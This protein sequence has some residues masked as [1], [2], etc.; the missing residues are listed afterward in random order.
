MKKVIV[1]LLSVSFLLVGCSFVNEDKVKIN[2]KNEIDKYYENLLLEDL[3]GVMK[4][5]SSDSEQYYDLYNEYR[6]TFKDFNYS[7]IPKE[8][9][10]TEISKERVVVSVAL[11]IEGVDENDKFDSFEVIH[12][13]SLKSYTDEIWKISSL[14][15]KYAFE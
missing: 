11:T 14:E 15:T 12:V 5:I 3:D 7:Y 2:V 1:I 8:I 6:A 10:F 9:S 13:F 4:Q